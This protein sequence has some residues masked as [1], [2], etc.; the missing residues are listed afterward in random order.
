[1]QDDVIGMA[2][3]KYRHALH[4]LQD[5][6]DAKKWQYLEAGQLLLQSAAEQ[7]EAALNNVDVTT[8]VADDL[9]LLS[10]QHRRVMRQLHQHMNRVKENIDYVD[11]SLSKTS[12]MA[13]FVA[14]DFTFPS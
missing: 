5:D 11:R 12:Y 7:L 3:Y 4:M 6:M 10:L 14:A 13:E 9:K 1:M 2:I 8:E